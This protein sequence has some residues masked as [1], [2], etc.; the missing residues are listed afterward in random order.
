MLY[1]AIHPQRK[2]QVQANSIFR[3]L[4]FTWMWCSQSCWDLAAN[5]IQSFCGFKSQWTSEW[6][7]AWNCRICRWSSCRTWRDSCEVARW[8][9]PK[10]LSGHWS[11]T[12]CWRGSGNTLQDNLSRIALSHTQIISSRSNQLPAGPFEPDSQTLDATSWI[13]FC[14]FKWFPRLSQC[15]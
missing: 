13:V 11:E 8:S 6:G 1:N 12:N 10:D 14:V 5:V 9:Q 2:S 7:V 4:A 3:S 15:H